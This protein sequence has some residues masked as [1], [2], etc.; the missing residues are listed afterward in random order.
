RGATREADERNAADL[1]ADPKEIAEHVMLV[2]LGRNDV[3]RV[4]EIGSVHVAYRMW[5]ERYSHVMHIVSN[6]EGRLRPGLTALDVLRAAC[7]AGTVSGAAEGAA[8]GS[9]RPSG[10]RPR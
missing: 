7:P 10:A 5:I 3:G 1:L 2:D 9:N 8:M 4:A 6:V